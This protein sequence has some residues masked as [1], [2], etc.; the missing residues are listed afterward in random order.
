M[1]YR[2]TTHKSVDTV[3]Q[4]IEAAAKQQGFG[5]LHSYDFRQTLAGKGFPIANEC[6]V[7]EVCNPRQA[8]EVLAM[9]MTLNMALPCRISVYEDAGQTVVGMIPPTAILGLVSDDP[10]VAPAAREVEDAME[11]IIDSVL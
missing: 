1:L 5:L 7:L 8:S 11:R 6:R 9:D 10:R 2:K 4:A 3:T